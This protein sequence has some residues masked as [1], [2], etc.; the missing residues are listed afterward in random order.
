MQCLL[1]QL[2]YN[3]AWFGYSI[4][5][6]NEYDEWATQLAT[7]CATSCGVISISTNE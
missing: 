5:N 6:L 4:S 3:L 7:R 1:N 2:V